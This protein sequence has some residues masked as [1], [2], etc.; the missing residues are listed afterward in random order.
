MSPSAVLFAARALDCVIA[1]VRYAANG[2]IPAH[3]HVEDGVSVILDGSVVEETRRSTAGASAGWTGFR[4][5][6]EVHTNRFGPAGACLFA[7]I[8]ERDLRDVLTRRWCWN[9]SPVAYRAGLRF[10][11]H[12][13]VCDD[14]CVDDVADLLAVFN[15]ARCD[16]PTS[17]RM[18][19]VRKR[20]EDPEAQTSV[21]TLAR[22]TGVHPVVLARQF[23]SAYGMSPREYRTF[24]MVRRALQ[25]LV[26][27]KA[28]IAE[29]AHDCGFA[30]HS[31]MCR[32][33]RVA[34][35]FSPRVVRQ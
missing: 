13:G 25:L 18:R 17:S 3:A 7:V 20:L 21:A 27:T 1:V 24:V 16:R 5:A 15:D 14:S 33:F 6:G 9:D 11:R 28:G 29:I 2:C 32:A 19:A 34:L 22:E 12:R 35:G 4:P 31:H 10:L 30:D 23:R 8:P 26:R